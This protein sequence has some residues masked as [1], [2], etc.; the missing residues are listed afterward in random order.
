[1]PTTP[2][3]VKAQ[4]IAGIRQLIVAIVT[5]AVIIGGL[6]LVYGQQTKDQQQRELDTIHAGLA[7]A[8]VLALPVDPETGRDPD[9][10]RNCFTQYDLEA[11]QLTAPD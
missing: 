9:A 10:V 5:A 2:L 3:T 6:S 1:M 4:V 7:T 11:P 8:C